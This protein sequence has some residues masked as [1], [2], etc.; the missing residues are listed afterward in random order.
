MQALLQETG[1][2]NDATLN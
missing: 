1:E 2:H